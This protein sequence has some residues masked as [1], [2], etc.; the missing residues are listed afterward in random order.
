MHY[1][2]CFSLYPT[3]YSTDLSSLPS[4][5]LA[6]PTLRTRQSVQGVC[7]IWTVS[8]HVTSHRDY[9]GELPYSSC[10]F[11]F[12]FSCSSCRCIEHRSLYL[13]PS[14]SFSPSHY[15]KACKLI[16]CYIRCCCCFCLLKQR[17]SAVIWSNSYVLS[18]SPHF[19]TCL[20]CMH[21]S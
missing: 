4:L 10:S 6:S 13:S 5:L 21:F 19:L 8:T 14:L 7:H 15:F 17:S 20:S 9:C 1:A 2:S 18:S 11:S 3:H 16:F 12:S